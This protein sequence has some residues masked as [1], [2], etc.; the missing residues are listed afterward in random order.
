[1][2]DAPFVLCHGDFHPKNVIVSAEG[3]VIVDWFDACRGNA[4]GDIARTSLLLGGEQNPVEHHLPGASQDVIAL[5]HRRYLEAVCDG[6]KITLG[7][8]RQWRTIQE[9]ARNAERTDEQK[10]LAAIH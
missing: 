8:V 7:S 1:M 2:L 5:L 6:T 4:V 9:A 10:T 3:P